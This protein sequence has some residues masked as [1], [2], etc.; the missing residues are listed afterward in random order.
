MG[1]GEKDI[2]LQYQNNYILADLLLLFGTGH[3]VIIHECFL[4]ITHSHTFFM[5]KININC[6]SKLLEALHARWMQL[7]Q[8]L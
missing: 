2:K 3:A 7:L 1:G 4:L 8:S 5:V 6:T